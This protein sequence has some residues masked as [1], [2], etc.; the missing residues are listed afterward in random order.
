MFETT[1]QYICN[2]SKNQGLP[3]GIWRILGPLAS[4]PTSCCEIVGDL[5]PDGS[6]LRRGL[7]ESG[8]CMCVQIH[9]IIAPWHH[10]YY[11]IMVYY[12]H[13]NYMK[14]W[15]MVY[16]DIILLIK[17]YIGHSMG[18]S[19]QSVLHRHEVCLVLDIVPSTFVS[20][21]KRWSIAINKSYPWGCNWC[22]EL[23]S[24]NWRI[25]YYNSGKKIWCGTKTS[26]VIQWWYV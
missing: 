11:D 15:P 13:Q 14:W 10:A 5:L 8:T 6:R 1:N 18:T 19:W 4:W 21:L 12:M 9:T 16:Y 23:Q 24:A 3:K 25:S 20:L 26:W 22:H 7:L 2:A 17:W